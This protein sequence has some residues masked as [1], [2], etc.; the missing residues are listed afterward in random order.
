MKRTLIIGIIVY[1]IGLVMLMAGMYIAF[2]FGNIGL[3]TL[4]ERFSM[5]GIC[6]LIAF[7]EINT[8]VGYI[9]IKLYLEY[10]D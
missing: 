1:I 9:I 10:K 3:V 8:A 4:K 6:A 5:L 2:K 7:G